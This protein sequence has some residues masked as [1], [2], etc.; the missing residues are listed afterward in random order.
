[1][2]ETWHHQQKFSFTGEK[3]QQ[4]TSERNQISKKSLLQKD[5]DSNVPL[6]T[7]LVDFREIKGTWT[8]K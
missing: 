5:S 4:N 2:I 8:Y 6:I 1:M 3:K 7:H